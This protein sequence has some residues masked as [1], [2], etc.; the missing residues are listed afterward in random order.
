MHAVFNNNKS[1]Q[2]YLEYFYIILFGN[3]ENSYSLRE[4]IPRGIN[5]LKVCAFVM[6]DN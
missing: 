1:M 3:F 2:R 6:Y 5:P 4:Y